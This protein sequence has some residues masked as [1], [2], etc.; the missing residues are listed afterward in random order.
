VSFTTLGTDYR[1][2]NGQYYE[3]NTKKSGINQKILNKFL[4]QLAI[5]EERHNKLFIYIFILDM[6]TSKDT[7]GII[8]C[9]NSKLE[10]HFKKYQKVND[11]AYQWV[12]EKV[13]NEPEHYHQVIMLDGNK[14]QNN[15]HIYNPMLDIWKSVGGNNI[16][17]PENPFYNYKR[18]DY[19]T[20]ADII[21]RV[22]YN[23]KNSTKYNKPQQ[24][25]NYGTSRIKPNI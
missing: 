7:N 17:R 15:K 21:Y 2:Y 25:K 13:N 9:F 23:A 22:S 6:K 19:K 3:V 16:H 24:T 14:I 12:R 10:R 18:G 11:M 4:E 5:M 20:M 1:L 8:S